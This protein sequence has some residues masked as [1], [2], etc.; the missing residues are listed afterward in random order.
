MSVKTPLLSPPPLH[1][2]Q[3]N[4]GSRDQVPARSGIIPVQ[5]TRVGSTAGFAG[6]AW[7][8]RET[9]KNPCS[10]AFMAFLVPEL[11]SEGQ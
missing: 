8:T 5:V 10:D 4:P 1:K 3:N 2:R 11:L 6:R 7:N 9:T